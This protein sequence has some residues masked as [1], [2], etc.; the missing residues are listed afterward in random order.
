MSGVAGEADM[1]G[2]RGER[3]LCYQIKIPDAKAGRCWSDSSAISVFLSSSFVS[4]SSV[5]SRTSTIARQQAAAR[6]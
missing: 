1:T 3:G 6:A 2:I 5:V 4:R